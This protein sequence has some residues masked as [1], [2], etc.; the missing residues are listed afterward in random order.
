MT[1]A[2]HKCND[3]TPTNGIFEFRGQTFIRD[4]WILTYVSESNTGDEL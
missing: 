2:G 1:K 4:K 3:C